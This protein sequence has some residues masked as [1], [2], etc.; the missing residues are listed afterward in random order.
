MKKFLYLLLGVIT[1]SACID[2]EEYNDNARGNFEALWHLMDEHYCFFTE[3]D[4]DWNDVHSRYSRQISD[5]MSS[6]QLFEVLGNMIG[7]LRDGH[8]NL[9]SSWDVARNW[10]W[11]ED[12]PDNYDENWLIQSKSQRNNHP[13]QKHRACV[14]HKNFGR[15]EIPD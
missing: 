7:E 11:Y 12:Y 2:E 9:S 14:A 3:K 13:P 10:S 15:M 4:V 6:H 5:A 8:V 1:L